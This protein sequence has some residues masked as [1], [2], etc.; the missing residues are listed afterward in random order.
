LIRWAEATVVDRRQ[1]LA[2]HFVPG[3]IEAEL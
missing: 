2:R 1:D 3:E